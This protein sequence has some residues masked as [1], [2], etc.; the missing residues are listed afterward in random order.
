[1]KIVNFDEISD[2]LAL[3]FQKSGSKIDARKNVFF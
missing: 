2:I 1:M 3:N